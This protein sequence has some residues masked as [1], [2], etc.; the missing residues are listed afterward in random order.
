MVVENLLELE[1]SSW[2]SL[3]LY[4][5]LLVYLFIYFWLEWCKIWRCNP[6][7][8]SSASG[9]FVPFNYGFSYL[10]VAMTGVC[11]LRWNSTIIICHNFVF[12]Y[13]TDFLYSMWQDDY[14]CIDGTITMVTSFV[15]PFVELSW[16]KLSLCCWTA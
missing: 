9:C 13:D 7:T 3:R 15:S 2:Y 11:V 10:C 5:G 8:Y 6:N 1:I 4:K 12:V 16:V 14:K